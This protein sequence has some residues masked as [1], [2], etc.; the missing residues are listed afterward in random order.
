MAQLDRPTPDRPAGASTGPQP[1]I[2]TIDAI[3]P[4]DRVAVTGVIIEYA[5]MAISG[6]PACR[7]TLADETGEVDLMFLGRVAIRGLEPGRR[8]SAEGTA[9]NRDGWLAIW[10]PRYQLHPADAP[11]EE[12]ELSPSDVA[13]GHG[14]VKSGVG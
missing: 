1:I 10:N 9:A 12:W 14:V 4:Q 5:A 6:C 2:T 7:Y 13:G 8:C 3:Q 11:D